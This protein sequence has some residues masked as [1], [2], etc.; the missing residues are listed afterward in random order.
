MSVTD[1]IL[2]QIGQ[3]KQ[4]FADV[5]TG[6]EAIVATLPATGSISEVDAQKIKA[7]LADVLTQASAVNTEIQSDIPPPPPPP[8]G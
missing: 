6:V 2:A 8:E 7:S 3:L 4:A 1:D 5:K